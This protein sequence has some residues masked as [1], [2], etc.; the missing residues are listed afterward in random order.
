MELQKE[1]TKK[2]IE[3]R[4]AKMGDYAKI[5]YLEGCLKKKTDLETRKFVLLKLSELYEA[6]RM[7]LDAAR[8]MSAASDINATDQA[9]INSLIKTA[10]FYIN[11]GGY[12]LADSAIIKAASLADARQKIEIKSKQKEFYKSQARAFISKEKRK[13]AANIYEKLL[14]L[15]LTGEERKEITANLLNLYEKLG[16]IKEYY[17]LK[18]KM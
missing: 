6:K 12:E 1:A 9:K 16:D 17:A 11:A 4:F 7:F 3:E 18:R 15:D 8:A 14:E 2:D 13:S 10:E 5:G